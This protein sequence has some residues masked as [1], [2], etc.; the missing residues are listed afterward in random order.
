VNERDILQMAALTR[1]LPLSVRFIEMMA[2]PSNRDLQSDGF[3]SATRVRTAIESHYGILTRA[4][5]QTGNGPA[6][7][8][9]L[10]G[11]R[12]TLG[13]ITPMSHSFCAS[14]NRLRLTAR[15]ELRLCLFDERDYPLRHLLKTSEP[16]AALRQRI[17]E[18]MRV[19]P[20]EHHLRSGT[21]GNLESFVQI[22]G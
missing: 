15:G 3:L 7:V 5:E 22:G 14:C 8:Y 21:S 1:D 2:T 4:P 19:K 11:H 10:P 6:R 13:F 12:G 17:L 9:R 20:E 16:E 18:L